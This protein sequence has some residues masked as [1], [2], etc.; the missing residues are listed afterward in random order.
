MNLNLQIVFEEL[1]HHQT[2]K[3]IFHN[4][5]IERK[6]TGVLPY[7]GEYA[8][9]AD[10]LYVVNAA[11]L[12]NTLYIEDTASF[13][14]IGTLPESFSIRNVEFV[15]IDEDIPLLTL[16]TEISEIFLR[17]HDWYM[18]LQNSVRQYRSLQEVGR[19]AE[20]MLRNPVHLFDSNCIWIFSSVDARHYTIPDN[21]LMSANTRVMTK[22]LTLPEFENLHNRTEPFY[23]FH[24]SFREFGFD[25]DSLCCNIFREN[26]YFAVVYTDNIGH[27]FTDRDWALLLVIRD[28][29]SDYIATRIMPEFSDSLEQENAAKKILNEQMLEES[30]LRRILRRNGW[31]IENQYVCIRVEPQ[32]SHHTETL[33][34]ALGES[35]VN[36][37]SVVMKTMHQGGLVLVLNLTHMIEPYQYVIDYI[38]N[39]IRDCGMVAGV[40]EVYSNFYSL[41]YSHKHA[42]AAITLGSQKQPGQILYYYDSLLL[43]YLQSKCLTDDPVASICPPGLLELARQDRDRETRDL[44]ILRHYLEHNMNAADTARAF[45]VHRNTMM[46]RIQRIEK[47][48][49][50]DLTNG[51]VRL[52]LLWSLRLLESDAD[53]PA[54]DS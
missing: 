17:Y 12:R 47:I 51:D 3:V 1:K 5:P 9:R 37:I 13:V 10:R 2:G 29:L 26:Q 53:R 41:I 43:E 31:D 45:Y 44:E 25:Y 34:H 23:I 21:Y 7:N 20:D 27:D 39:Q 40:S 11:D 49:N 18:E 54:A 48:L 35:I 22:M 16:L 42:K 46:Y 14:V 38:R 28:A 24:D 19:I 4:D 6:L 32:D 50:M 33:F 15:Q 30:M 36:H 8:P 52:L